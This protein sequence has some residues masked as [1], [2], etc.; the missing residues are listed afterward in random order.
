MHKPPPTHRDECNSIPFKWLPLPWMT[1]CLSVCL[2]LLWQWLLVG[3]G[4]SGSR[5]SQDLRLFFG[6]GL[7]TA[8]LQ[9][10]STQRQCHGSTSPQQCRPPRLSQLE[11]TSK[12]DHRLLQFID[13]S[14]M[15][16]RG[17]LEE[18]M[19]Q[20]SLI[21]AAEPQ[22]RPPVLLIMVSRSWPDIGAVGGRKEEATKSESGSCEIDLI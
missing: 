14:S 21:R 17:I 20:R 13:S 22:P 2:W 5:I 15:H 3:S 10:S 19:T 1:F 12:E 9:L 6:E 11:K 8:S 7:S 16:F 4:I 18:R